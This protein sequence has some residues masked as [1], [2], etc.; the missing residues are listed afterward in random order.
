MK[1]LTASEAGKLGA[2]ASI[3]SKSIAR[4]AEVEKYLQ[5]PI[6]CPQCCEIILFEK[7]IKR[8]FCSTSCYN[9]YCNVN[10]V[11]KLDKDN[12]CLFCGKEV[13]EKFCSSSCQKA[14][15]WQHERDKFV[16]SGIDTSCN[17]R[18]G[19]RYLIELHGIKCM[20]CQLSTWLY[21]SIPLVLD[22]IDGNSDNNQMNNL[23]IICNNCDAILPTFKNNNK[24]AGRFRKAKRAARYKY[25]QSLLKKIELGEIILNDDDSIT[26]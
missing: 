18:V 26:A 3:A 9:I 20:I 17:N 21:K 2:I 15:T 23:R 14:R 8:V 25:E 4:D 1:R 11:K 5:N 16:E 22:H 13:K 19:K 24:Q 12:N 7:R 6:R 10:K